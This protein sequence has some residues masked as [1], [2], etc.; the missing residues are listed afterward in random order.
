MSMITIYDFI[1]NIVEHELSILTS[2]NPVKIWKYEII[3][4]K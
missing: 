2:N 1:N 3:D 4:N